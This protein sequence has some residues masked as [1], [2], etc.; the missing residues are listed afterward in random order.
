MLFS[1]AIFRAYRINIYVWCYYFD[2]H[3]VHSGWLCAEQPFNLV[4]NLYEHLIFTEICNV[5]WY[6]FHIQKYIN[7]YSVFLYKRWF[8]WFIDIFYIYVWQSY[9]YF[10]RRER[11]CYFSRNWAKVSVD[12]LMQRRVSPVHCSLL[13]CGLT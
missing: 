4:H 11:Q 5:T 6:T 3:W 7:R 9:H 12:M 8:K 10:L 2:V 13:N 1:S